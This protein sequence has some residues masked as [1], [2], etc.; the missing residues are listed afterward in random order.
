[1]KTNKA[2]HLDMLSKSFIAVIAVYSVMTVA[3]RPPIGVDEVFPDTPLAGDPVVIPN[4]HVQGSE[5]FLPEHRHILEMTGWFAYADSNIDSIQYYQFEAFS[6]ARGPAVGIAQYLNG[7]RTAFIALKNRSDAE[8]CETI[9]H[10]A[11]HLTGISQ[12]GRMYGE[13]E[14]QAAAARFWQE[15]LA[16]SKR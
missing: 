1:M 15:W 12:N 2:E 5:K 9:V 6:T 11:G 10:E 7:K 3:C 4:S 13:E 8:V 16:C 14:A